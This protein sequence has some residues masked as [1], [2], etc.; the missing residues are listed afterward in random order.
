MTSLAYQRPGQDGIN[1]TRDS[2]ARR[3]V[4]TSLAFQR[5]GQGKISLTKDSD[6]RRFVVTS[7][8]YQRPGQDGISLTRDSDA[9][10]FVV[11]SL[12]SQFSEF[13]RMTPYPK[14]ESRKRSKF[15]KMTIDRLMLLYS[16]DNDHKEEEEEMVE[17]FKA[18]LKD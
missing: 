17:N 6:A 14:N 7:L 15:Y 2:D 18:H 1:L 3:F 8:A 16:F 10:R 9:R 12:V 13:V 4:V 11:T 5:P